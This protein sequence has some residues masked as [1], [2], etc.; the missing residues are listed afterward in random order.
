MNRL[1]M[2]LVMMLAIFGMVVSVSAM[3]FGYEDNAKTQKGFIH[4][5]YVKIGVEMMPKGYIHKDKGQTNGLFM[6]NNPEQRKLMVMNPKSSDYRKLMI[7]KPK[8]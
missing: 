7:F 6:N 8:N 5:D 2:S 4:N 3:C 1:F